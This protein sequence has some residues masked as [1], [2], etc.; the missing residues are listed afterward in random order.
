MEISTSCFPMWKLQFRRYSALGDKISK[1]KLSWLIQQNSCS[2]DLVQLHHIQAIFCLLP[3]FKTPPHS[4]YGS[5]GS[6]RPTAW[7]R[8]AQDKTSIVD[9]SRKHSRNLILVVAEMQFNSPCIATRELF[10]LLMLAFGKEGLDGFL[11]WLSLFKEQG[12]KP[13]TK[14]GSSKHANISPPEDKM[15]FNFYPRRF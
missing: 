6:M 11:I 10:R 9:P 2:V 1:G 15:G 5:G 8:G 13:Q 4:I 14:S 12:D 7:V 3:L